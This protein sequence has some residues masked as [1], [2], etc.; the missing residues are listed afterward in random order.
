MGGLSLKVPPTLLRGTMLY[1]RQATDSDASLVFAWHQNPDIYQGFYHNKIINWKEHYQWWTVTTKDWYK[2]II[3]F[4]DSNN[5]TRPIGIIRISPKE[6]W[7]PEIGFTIGEVSLWGQG[8]G[9]Q[10]V[11]LALDWLKSKGYQAVHTTVPSNNKR[12]MELLKHIGFEY[13]G[14]AREGEVW[15]QKNPL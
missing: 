11:I 5:L 12:T 13:M 7:S 8:Y 1:L 6:S 10:S 2:F 14:K 15:L 9:R 4:L 3:M